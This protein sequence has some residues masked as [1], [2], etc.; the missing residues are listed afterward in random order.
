M[1]GVTLKSVLVSALVGLTSIVKAADL[2]AI[3]VVGNKFFYSNNGS[4]FYIKGIAY[5]QNPE[6]STGTFVDPLAN[7]ETCKRDIAYLSAIDT[8]VI[9]VYALDVNEDHTE[10]MQALADAGIYI[11]ADLSQPDESINRKDPQWTLDL[12]QRYTDVVDKFHNYT[13]VL[14]FFAGNEVT[15]DDTNTA[16]SAYVKAAIRDTKAY[17]KAKNYRSIPVGYSSNDDDIIR[18]ALADYFACGNQDERADF[19]GINMYEWCGTQ[20]YQSSGYQNATEDYKNLGI[21]IFFS[22]YGCNQVQPRRFEEVSTLF[23]SQ[24]TDVWSGGIVYMYFEEEN[25]Y[26]LVSVDSNGKVSTLD[27]YNYYK[28][29]IKKISPSSAS[30]NSQNATGASSPTSCPTATDVWAASTELPPT[31]D[32]DICDCMQSSLK[33]VVKDSVDDEDYADL[34]DYVCAKVDCSG[35]S[36]NGTTG[37]YGAYSP[38]SPKEKLSFV[39][40]LYYLDQGESSSACDF[41]GSASLKSASTAS[42]CSA[43][44]SSAGVSGLGSIQGSVRTDTSEATG[45]NGKSGSSSGSSSTSSG[46]S[47]SSSG[48][49]DKKSAASSV[50]LTAFTKAGVIGLSMIVGFGMIM[51]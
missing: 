14:G 5:Q 23:G 8:N 38:C 47:S 41:S 11:I 16:A 19:F 9:R 4:Q 24:M 42:S 3:E 22:E 36:S 35:I 1:M 48:S 49:S 33:C 10:C 26:G 28:S 7:A 30:I 25:N 18:V 21:P 45:S 31:P 12:F 34:Y 20:T 13:N 43:Y 40:N 29:E 50:T 17:I 37:K 15:N 27:D 44:L 2:P 46:S 6:N 39:F 32:K 51:I